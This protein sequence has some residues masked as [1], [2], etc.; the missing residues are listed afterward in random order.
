MS[1]V[2]LTVV[3]LLGIA[4][5]AQWRTKYLT[6]ARISGLHRWLPQDSTCPGD[7]ANDQWRIDSFLLPAGEDPMDMVYTATGPE[8]AWTAGRYPLFGQADGLPISAQFLQRNTVVGKPGKI[9]SIAVSSFTMVA[10]NQFP[11]GEYTLGMICTYFNQPALYWDAAITISA[12]PADG[13]PTKLTWTLHPPEGGEA[14]IAAAGVKDDGTN[15]LLIVTS[16]AAALAVV[17]GLIRLRRNNPTKP[18]KETR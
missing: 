8:P 10:Q 1:L 7:S 16:G 5:S 4:V 17:V 9:L 13:D 6:E 3:V 18:T 12:A 2:L 11:G 15:W 14:S